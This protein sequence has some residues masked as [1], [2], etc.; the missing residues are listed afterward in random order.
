MTISPHLAT[1]DSQSKPPTNSQKA[2]RPKKSIRK[3]R[4]NSYQRE[5]EKL[6][7]KTIKSPAD[8]FRMEAFFLKKRA[9]LRRKYGYAIPNSTAIQALVKLSPIIEIGAGN[10]YWAH[11]ISKAGGKIQAFDR[12]IK[13]NPYKLENFYFP[14][15]Q[16]DEEILLQTPGSHTLLLCWPPFN[17]EMAAKALQNYLGDRFVYIGEPAYGCTGDEAFHDML[18]EKWILKKTIS[19]PRWPGLKDSLFIYNRK[20]IQLDLTQII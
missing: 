13:N 3:A 1:T 19:I 2:R 18:E 7:R 16:G 12:H 9:Q 20:I 6:F 17:Q 14:V 4:K 10:G 11:L 8:W 15:Q 5:Y